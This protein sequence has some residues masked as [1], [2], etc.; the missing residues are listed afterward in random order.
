MSRF[1]TDQLTFISIIVLLIV[2]VE[3]TI[4]NNGGAFLLIIGALL[5]YYSFSKNKRSFFWVGC[6][7][8]FMAVLTVWSL[9]LLIVGVLIYLLYKHATKEPKIVVVDT[10][11]FQVKSIENNQLIGTTS[12]PIENYK[13]QDV[14][15]QRF[16]GDITIDTTE[17]ILPAGTSVISIRQ[18]IGKVMVVVPY[19]VPF[20]LQFSTILGEA[21]LL[22]KSS[23]RLIN[24]Q[25]VFEDGH[26]EEAK[27]KLV[28]H[29]A[30]WLGDVEVIRK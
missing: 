15:I 22:R 28:I 20:R 1:S 5:I 6:F 21:K 19:E 30:T 18:S 8:L 29:V 13:W 17:T 27:R 24:E 26:P 16:L 2:F 14:Q 3:L 23:K 4:F 9:R 11:D 10:N 25:I 7:F 12:V